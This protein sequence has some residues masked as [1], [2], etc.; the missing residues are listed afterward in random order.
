MQ[1]LGLVI[2]L[3]SV[4]G[5]LNVIFFIASFLALCLIVVL[6]GMRILGAYDDTWPNLH[7]IMIILIFCLFF[8]VLIPDKK[9]VVAMY[10]GP[11]KIE[12]ILK[13]K[14]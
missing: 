14:Q 4:C 2:Y 5:T 13:E 3:A 11:E 12:E 1:D 8:L 7:T 9:T 10:I 6:G